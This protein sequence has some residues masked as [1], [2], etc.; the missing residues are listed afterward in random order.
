MTPQIDAASPNWRANAPRAI[1]CEPISFVPARTRGDHVVH[2]A[3]GTAALLRPSLADRASNGGA[4]R[5]DVSVTL[6]L[7]ALNFFYVGLALVGLW[8][9]ASLRAP[10]APADSRGASLSARRVCR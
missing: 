6:L 2:A 5:K 1:R 8:P 4:I 7:G 3:H 9:L 10:I